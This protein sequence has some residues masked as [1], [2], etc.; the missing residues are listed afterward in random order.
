MALVYGLVTAMAFGVGDF[1]AGQVTKRVPTLLVVLYAQLVGVMMMLPV[2]LLSGQ[3]ASVQAFIWG[4]LGGLSLGIGFLFYFSALSR[5]KMGVVS[6]VTGILSAIVP[7]ATGLAI[8]ERPGAG[9]LIAVVL[10]A[11]AIILISKKEPEKQFT[12]QAGSAV[13]I[14]AALAGV[15][16]GL[17]F[18]F[19]HIPA[20]DESM[21]TV[22]F[23]M[24][25]AFTA[26]AALL[27][28]RRANIFDINR[29]A[30]IF[31]L[32]NGFLQTFGAMTYVLGVS[33]GLMSIVALAGALSPLFNSLSSAPDCSLVNA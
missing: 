30:W 13:L 4:S 33:I 21:W 25:G 20:N 31:I 8:G 18:V 7:V 19:L 22:F 32:A 23:T 5:G 3:A 9:A 2:G 17:L 10:I 15:L 29:K 26:V 14:Q 12:S 11:V 28:F 16:I 24:T 6:S 27:I 1:L